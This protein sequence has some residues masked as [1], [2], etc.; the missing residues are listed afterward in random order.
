MKA[1]DVF[2]EV[3]NRLEPLVQSSCLGLNESQLEFRPDADANS[4]AWLIWHLTRVQDDHIAG[5]VNGE[6][7]W[8]K[9]KWC[10]RF[11]L[12]LPDDATGFGHT[13]QDVAKVRGLSSE[14]LVGY[15]AQVQER[16]VSVLQGLTGPDL[17]RV[18]DESYDPPVTVGARLASVVG[19]CFEHLGQAAYV[20]GLVERRVS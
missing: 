4:I 10:A 6:Q 11:A 19:E 15:C 7:V 18:I 20:R 12:D 8:F 5:L 3:F 13:S 1:L 2:V 14:L 16:T 9:E 17:D